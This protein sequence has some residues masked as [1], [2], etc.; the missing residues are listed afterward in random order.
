M[1]LQKAITTA[2]GVS[3][4]EAYWVPTS[5]TIKGVEL[6]AR[7]EFRPYFDSAARSQNL[8][9]LLGAPIQVLEVTGTDFASSQLSAPTDPSTNY[10]VI[11]GLA[12]ELAKTRIEYFFDAEDV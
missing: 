12:Y 4:P 11:A 1:A 2:D 3:A 8:G 7:F 9:P 6:Y 5:I 10:S